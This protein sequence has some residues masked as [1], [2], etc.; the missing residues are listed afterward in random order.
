MQN[1]EPINKQAFPSGEVRVFKPDNENVWRL[2][3]HDVP[4]GIDYGGDLLGTAADDMPAP[5]DQ[6]AENV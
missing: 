3:A 2:A 6:G 5:K 1:I 4:P